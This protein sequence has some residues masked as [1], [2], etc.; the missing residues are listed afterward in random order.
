MSP[1]LSQSLFLNSFHFRT[2]LDIPI[3]EGDR[4]IYSAGFNVDYRLQDTKR[5]DDEIQDIQY[6]RKHRAK[7][8]I[9]SHQGS[10]ENDSAL[11]LEFI[12]DYLSSQLNQ[13]VHYFPENA[14]PQ[15]IKRS[16]EMQ[17][18]EIVLFGNTRHH[19]GEEKGCSLLAREFSKLGRFVA[20]GGFSKAHRSHASN[21]K[22]LSYL[23]GFSTLS[24]LQELTVLERFLSHLSNYTS[25][26]ILGGTKIEKT[27]VGLD[28]FLSY[29]DFLIPSGA[30]LNNLLK[31]LGLDICDSYLGED[32]LRSHN[33][34]TKLLK[35]KN[36]AE[37]IIPKKIIVTSTHK[38]IRSIFSFEQLIPGEKIVDFHFD[39]SSTQLKHLLQSRKLFTVVAGVPCLSEHG[40]TTATKEI[41]N[42]INQKEIIPFL[43]GGDTLRTFQMNCEK[44]SGGG[45]TLHYLQFKTCPVL[46]ALRKNQG[47]VNEIGI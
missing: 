30:V 41:K 45:A 29:F 38:K 34:I 13:K 10:F 4:W 5:I 17:P 47:I 37:L 24:F 18:G 35:R 39:F 7:V 32:P 16:L 1:Y 42:F 23:P 8:A 31:Y 46:E 15:A 40:F 12:A 2:I 33:S 11:H 20:I 26:G 36:K 44:S 27:T 25:L 9:L 19:L 3:K 43:I 21:T 14:S 28:Y 6:L 22:I